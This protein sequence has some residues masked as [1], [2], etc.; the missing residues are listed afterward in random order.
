MS[1]DASATDSAPADNSLAELELIHT[2]RGHV[3]T[4]VW[5]VAWSPSGKTLASCGADRTIRL[6]AAPADGD[7]AAWKCTAVLEEGHQRTIRC[8]AWSPCGRFIASCSFDG[9]AA[10][11]ECLDDEFDC[12][13][14]LEGHASW[15]LGAAFAPDGL[16]LASCGAGDP[17]R[18]E[19]G[20]LAARLTGPA[21]TLALDRS[22]R[23]HLGRAEPAVPADTP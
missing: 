5:H 14:S 9:T 2:L 8:C 20:S 10:V 16:V 6:W 22:F 1:A 21:S 3:E 13:A 18:N 4:R 7:G 23:A 15:V 19:P 11:W 17:L 12:V